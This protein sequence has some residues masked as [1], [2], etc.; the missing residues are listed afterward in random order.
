MHHIRFTVSSSLVMVV[1]A[2]LAQAQQRTFVSGL[3]S[4][5]NNCNRTGPCRTIGQA[6]SI[7]NPGGEVIVLDSAGYGPFTVSKSISITAPPGVYA[8]ISVFS[9]DGITVNAAASD[10]VVLRGLT[11]N[12]QGSLGNGILLLGGK[13]QIDKC[14]VN[15]FNSSAGLSLFEVSASAEV[16]DSFFRGNGFGIGATQGMTVAIDR[17]R[18]EGNNIGLQADAGAQVTVRNSLV[19]DNSTG[20]SALSNNSSDV[21]LYIENCVASGNSGDGVV[22]RSLTT[23]VAKVKLSNST[24]TNNGTGLH[25]FGSPAM[26]LSRGNNTVEGNTTN[27]MGTIG[28]YGPK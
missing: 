20:F 4:D 3:G 14:V 17:V 7:T 22:A 21:S 6:I 12:N 26:L 8:G 5:A 18:V 2:S 13:L 16:K 10:T 28:S 1:L 11:V 25:N 19:S 24:I 15:G 23:G 9:G 27:T